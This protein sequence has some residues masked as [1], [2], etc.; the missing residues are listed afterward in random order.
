VTVRLPSSLVANRSERPVAAVPRL[1]LMVLAVALA[2]QLAWHGL[3]PEA[4]ERMRDLPAV[5]SDAALRLTALGEEPAAARL[6]M[7]WLQA[8]DYQPG[9]SVP[10]ARLDYERLAGWLD[11]I[12]S[13]DPRSGYPLLS[14]ARV[15]SQVPDEAR[16]RRM[17]AFVREKFAED[18][19]DRWQWMA[20]A[21]YVAK[22]LLGDLDLALELAREL[23]IRTQP[24]EAPGWARQMELFVLEDLGDVEGARILLGGLIESGAITDANEIRFLKERLGVE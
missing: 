3:R 16:Q 4:G 11:R 20:H 2:A 23:R 12:L 7:L 22:H 13:L 15:Y 14:A 21:V 24:G 6:W 5:P 8:F 10:F 9:I 1:V 17:V 18:P 19:A